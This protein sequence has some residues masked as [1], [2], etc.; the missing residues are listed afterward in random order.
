VLSPW[1]IAI[2]VLVVLLLYGPQRLPEM[3]RSLGKGMRELRDS[4]SGAESEHGEL[5][6]SAVAEEEP[7]GSRV[8]ERDALE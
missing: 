4:I 3:G 2:F 7:L 6:Q 8:H 5:S 1:H